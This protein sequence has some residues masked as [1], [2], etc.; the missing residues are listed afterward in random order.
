MNP[1]LTF[2]SIP[3]LIYVVIKAF[4]KKDMYLGLCLIFFLSL[5]L[6]SS[7]L[8]AKW[9]RYII[10][11][12]PFLYIMSSIFL[13][14][15][16][17]SLNEKSKILI[18]SAIIVVS[19]FYSFSF[20]KT[21]RMSSDTRLEAVSFAKNNIPPKSRILS[22]A[23]DLGITPFNSY[24]PNI[25]LFNFYDMESDDN[26]KEEL[27]Y[28]LKSADYIIL[29]SQRILRSR[30]VNREHFPTGY[31]FYLNLF[32]GKLGF[33]KLYETPCDIFCKFV[34]LGDPVFN[35]EETANV[36]DRPTV[37]IFKKI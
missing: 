23:Y 36:F 30:I 11:I 1:L 28:L 31:N 35:V 32:S 25:T 33:E 6:P 7:F 22:E 15:L 12:L 16:V 5:F 2:I 13:V 3:A 18:L 8:F 29:P 9:T 17:K 14:D 37:F 4:R 20:I 10:P 34:Y 21:V 19:I 26:K 24:F 27:R